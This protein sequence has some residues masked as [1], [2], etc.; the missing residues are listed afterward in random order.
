[1]KE[2]LDLNSTDLTE[3]KTATKYCASKD[4][5][6]FHI[7]KSTAAGYP[8]I[9]VAKPDERKTESIAIVCSGPSLA[10]TWEQVKMCNH[11]LTCSGAHDYLIERGIIPNFHME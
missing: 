6:N 4:L 3:H 10:Q 5:H 11:V 2:L 9:P 7:L 1:M 8:P